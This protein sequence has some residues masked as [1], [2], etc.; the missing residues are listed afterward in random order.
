MSIAP[1]PP[2][3]LASAHALIKAL[4]ASVDPPAPNWPVKLVIAN[5]AL[6]TDLYLPNK[7]QIIRDW[8]ID[9]WS[10]SRPESLLEPEFHDLLL[11]LPIEPVDISSLL[12]S[13]LRQATKSAAAP[14]AKAG[15]TFRALSRSSM[16]KPEAWSE[17]WSA[18]LAYL[19]QDN[20][21]SSDW[22]DFW[23]LICR[24]WR[25]ENSLENRKKVSTC[26]NPAHLPDFFLDTAFT[27][28]LGKS[29]ACSHGDTG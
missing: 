19:N 14:H 1:I 9:T 2:D 4:K 8:I 27:T 13:Y 3:Y 17:A 12:V 15:V 25:P 16:I 24:V 18:M 29:K 10:R 6:S 26:L 5:Q 23:T 7:H 22:Y 21:L 20:A 11:R 28:P